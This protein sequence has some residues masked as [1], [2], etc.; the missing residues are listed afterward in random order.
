MANE[1][2]TL[3]MDER[4]DAL[5][6]DEPCRGLPRPEIGFGGAFDALA[7]LRGNARDLARDRRRRQRAGR[8][9]VT[10]DAGAGGLQRDAARD[11]EDRGL[12]RDVVDAVLN[13]ARR[14]DRG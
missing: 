7:G 14:V 2:A 10:G 9:R 13:G 4:A 11:A 12:G 1:T 8:H 3:S 6:A 5:H